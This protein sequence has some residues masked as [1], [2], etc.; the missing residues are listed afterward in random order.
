MV[1]PPI[2]PEQTAPPAPSRL[3]VVSNREPYEHRWVEEQLVCQRTDGGLTSA[4]DPVLCRLGGTWV[5]WGSGDGDRE[6]VNPGDVTH[7]PPD[8]PAYRLRR[9]WLSRDE[10]KGGYLGYANQVLWPLCHTTLD[11]VM[12]SKSS[13]EGYVAMNRRFA[14]A[15]LDELHDRPGLVWVHDFH[16][17][18]VPGLIKAVRPTTT[19]AVF[20]HIP[21]PGPDVF[22][23]LPERREILEGLLAADSLVFQTAGSAD[24]FIDCARQFLQAESEI[25]GKAVDYKGHRTWIAAHAI[26]VDYQTFAEQA[27]TVS[28]EQAIRQARERLGVAPGTR[29]GIGVD[30]LD[31]TK[32]LLKRFWALD[33]FFARHPHYRGSFTFVQIAVPTRSEVE[34]YRRYREVI[35]QTVSVINDRY[36]QADWR[37][38]VYLEGRIRFET[39]VAYYRMADL[40][41]VSSVNDGMNLVAKEYVASQVDER[42]V[43]LVSQM[44]GAAEELTE[45][46]IINPYDAEGTAD[47]VAQ[48]LEMPPDERQRRMRTMRTYLQTHDIHAWVANCL[49]EVGLLLPTRH[50]VETG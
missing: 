38:I 2:R 50:E 1:R 9:V 22:R 29:L 30:R 17:A 39:L 11:R 5:A 36:G 20:W 43:L 7:V 41:L 23:I 40:A 42:G 15:L 27:G 10:V 4:L 34:T 31:Y 26:S 49:R 6:A 3:I 47:A 18:L 8:A 24:L 37:P 32:G 35:R 44:A 16:L 33:A 14:E 46:L 21:W 12:Y 28:V 48:A 45:A 13:W 25:T 19:V